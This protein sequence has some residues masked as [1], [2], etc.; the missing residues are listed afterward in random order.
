MP[1]P[2]SAGAVKETEACVEPVAVALTDVG[3]PGIDVYVERISHLL[4]TEEYV[5]T[6]FKVV[7]NLVYPLA[8]LTGL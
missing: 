4:V 5:S 1:P 2:V 7:L 3:A 8:G 6:A